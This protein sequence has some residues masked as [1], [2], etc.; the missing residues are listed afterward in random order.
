MAAPIRGELTV[1]VAADESQPAFEL[2]KP[3]SASICS[4]ICVAERVVVPLVSKDAVMSASPDNSLG[5]TS[6]PLL[7]K[8]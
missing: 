3:P 7:I 4:A 2:M 1:V 5:S 6:P 8:S